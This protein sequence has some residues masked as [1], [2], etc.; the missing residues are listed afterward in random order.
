MLI[1][2][3]NSKSRFPH[4]LRTKISSK[5]Q[6]PHKACSSSTQSPKVRCIGLNPAQA[7]TETSFLWEVNR[8]NIIL[9]H[10]SSSK[11]SR[12]RFLIR[13]LKQKSV[14]NNLTHIKTLR[15]HLKLLI[16]HLKPMVRVPIH[17]KQALPKI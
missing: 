7:Q 10:S 15:S 13:T 6:D 9:L 8:F 4:R 5:G 12:P 2:L 14:E 17:I 16:I 3:N 11:I 1:I